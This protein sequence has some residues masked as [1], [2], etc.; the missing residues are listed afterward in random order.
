MKDMDI[1]ILNMIIEVLIIAAFSGM[2]LFAISVIVKVVEK[3]RIRQKK[4]L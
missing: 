3:N 2:M 4:T 1:L